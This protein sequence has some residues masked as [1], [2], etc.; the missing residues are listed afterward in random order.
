MAFKVV[1]L[2][3]PRLLSGSQ[4]CPREQCFCLDSHIKRYPAC[5]SLER[6]RLF[7]HTHTAPMHFTYGLVQ[8]KPCSIV[9]CV[10]VQLW[11]HA[12]SPSSL[13]LNAF[14][15]FLLFQSSHRPKV[16]HPF[17]SES[18]SEV[19]AW[20]CHLCICTSYRVDLRQ[21]HFSAQQEADGCKQSGF[22]P[23]S[24][25]MPCINNFWRKTLTTYF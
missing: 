13:L 7:T 6:R 10:L 2:I 15:K 21:K 23:S 4:P 20:M 25:Q 17:G 9:T 3:R 8:C 1:Q 11:K 22:V 24:E 19:G 12:C 18:I 5:A 16:L 14:C